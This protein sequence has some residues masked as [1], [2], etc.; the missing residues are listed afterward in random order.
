MFEFFCYKQLTQD[1]INEADLES[2]NYFCKMGDIL[3]FLLYLLISIFAFYLSWE[4]NSQRGL[5]TFAKLFYGFFAFTF[6]SMYLLF[7][8]VFIN[9][10]CVPIQ[11]I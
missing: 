3:S 7:Y 6:G 11:K 10:T 4:C 9:G 8:I 2:T 5:S 1:E